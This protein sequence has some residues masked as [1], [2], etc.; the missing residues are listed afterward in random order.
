[1]S[2]VFIPG[3]ADEPTNQYAVGI[4][5][6]LEINVQGHDD[7][8]TVARVTSDGAISFPLIGTI[9]VKGK[10]LSEI[11]KEISEK[12]ADGFVK[13]PVVSAV[14]SST[15]SL[16]FFVYGEVKSPGRYVL[17]EDMTVLKAL[18]A[19]GGVTIDGLY[20]RVK[21][22]RKQKDK[23]EYEEIN[24]SLHNKHS[25]TGGDM[26]LQA[27]DIIIVERNKDF[28][29]YGEVI[30]PGKFTL[31]NN[32]TVLKAISLAGGFAKYGSPDRVK[33]LRTVPGKAEYE[34]IKV[35][36]K[37]AENGQNGKDVRLEPD[38]IVVALKGML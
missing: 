13:Y 2:L 25:N 21:L 26:P 7:L 16:K 36:V 24:I 5:D 34:T 18:S 12:L 6:V 31:E 20:G 29:V 28:Y 27:E 19:S 35:D 8:K 38:D 10:S 17:E 11:E 22:K 30:K 32:M 1:M 9:N 3:Y 15:R 33:I 37:G 14:L 4:D 23:P